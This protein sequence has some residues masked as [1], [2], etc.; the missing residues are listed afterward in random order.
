MATEKGNLQK[1]VKAI[2]EGVK[3]SYEYCDYKAITNSSVQQHVK[4]IHDGES[5]VVVNIVI[6]RQLQNLTFNNM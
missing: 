6:I 2:H 3:Y 4:S 5:N 1:H